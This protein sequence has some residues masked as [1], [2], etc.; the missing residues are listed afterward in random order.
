VISNYVANQGIYVGF[1]RR[2]TPAD[3]R[4]RRGAYPFD[5]VVVGFILFGE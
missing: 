3:L 5:A 4:D 2:A 1:G